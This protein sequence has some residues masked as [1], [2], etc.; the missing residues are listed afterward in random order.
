MN[1]SQRP[2]HILCVVNLP[3][4][5]RLG[6]IRVWI[7]L[8]EQWRAAGHS[9]DHFS[10]DDAFPKPISRNVIY[11]ARQLLFARRAARF[12]RE[13]AA[14]YDVI[15]SLLGTLPFPKTRLRFHGLL[16][17][18]SVGFYWLY[19]KFERETRARW[20]DLSRGK[21]AGRLFYSFTR[22]LALRS[23]A[24]AVE[25]ADLLNLPNADELQ[26][27]RDDLGSDKPAIVQPYGLTD[28]RR[29]QLA[30]IAYSPGAR[31][32][33]P[34]I[35]FLGMWSVRKGARDLSEIVRRIRAAIPTVTFRFLGTFTEDS[36]VWRDLGLEQ[37]DWC[38]IIRE[39]PPA[40]LPALLKDCTAGI[41]PSYVEGF[42]LGLLEQLA[43]K[44]P[45]VA[46]DAPG[47]RQILAPIRRE[48]LVPAGDITAASERIIAILRSSL[49]EYI[50]LSERCS[51]IAAEYSWSQIAAATIDAYR[52]SLPTHRVIFTQ[53]FGWRSSG[54]G[55]R[56]M[57]ALL[58]DAPLPF[59]I[60]ST[61]PQRPPSQA[62]A[63]ETHLPLRP[64]FGRLELTRGAGLAHATSALFA[65]RFRRRLARNCR[66]ARAIHAV[67]HGGLDF[68]HAFEIAEK[69]GVP[70]FLHV[71]DD[72]IYT[73]HVRRAEAD[74]AISRA[75]SGAAARFVICEKLGQEYQRRYGAAEYVVITDGLE[76]I[77]PAPR[78]RALGRLRVYFMGLFHLEYEPNLRALV[79][80]LQSLEQNGLPVSLTMRCGGL[81]RSMLAEGNFIRV[82]PFADEEQIEHDL[83]EADLLYLPLPFDDI[84]APFVRFSLSTKLITYLGSGVPILYHGP[85]ESA[86][87]ELLAQHDAAFSVHSLEPAELANPLRDFPGNRGRADSIVSHALALARTQFSLPRI[88]EKFWNTISKAIAA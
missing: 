75:W 49:P 27:L 72:F 19:E 78:A 61:L 74:A 13:N 8:A 23:A 64:H 82:L 59:E 58:R 31:L 51:A 36:L 25:H 50:A 1:R 9:V 32:A 39:Y 42:G 2:L 29:H 34:K 53:P 18:R 4:D 52:G 30:Q 6:A 55:A 66:D 20:P 3:W 5:A 12:I 24:K 40:Q 37:C 35:S 28:E 54:G 85:S 45:T 17:A 48:L 68:A 87:S 57:R 60:L 62:E 16:V 22:R 88:R 70:F 63:R 46:Y 81:R 79:H 11:S 80:A 77:A 67:A 56:I 10:L 15:D 41:F 43:A 84:H 14:R 71:H 44:I 47:P 69:L 65:K 26:S 33:S 21:I 86:V 7:E 83:E 73:A 76:R 38:E